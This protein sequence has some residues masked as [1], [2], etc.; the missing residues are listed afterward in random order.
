M[1]LRLLIGP[2]SFSLKEKF[3]LLNLKQEYQEQ[4]KGDIRLFRVRQKT[5]LPSSFPSS[6]VKYEREGSFFFYKKKI[7]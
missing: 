5:D 6:L 2:I 7:I 4:K 1:R 3:N